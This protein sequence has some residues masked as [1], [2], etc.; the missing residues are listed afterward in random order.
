MPST[1]IDW[2]ASAAWA[3]CEASS[4][5]RLLSAER[6]DGSFGPSFGPSTRRFGLIV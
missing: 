4:G 3:M 5:D 6:S 2:P 1:S